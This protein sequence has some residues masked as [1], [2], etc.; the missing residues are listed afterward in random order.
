MV[1]IEDHCQ[2][3]I[4]DAARAVIDQ[5]VWTRRFWAVHR[6]ENQSQA[7]DRFVPIEV[8]REVTFKHAH[9]LLVSR[10][11]RSFV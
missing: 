6:Q 1:R 10:R 5:K 8:R 4:V 9:K 11:A 7:I 2:L 3:V